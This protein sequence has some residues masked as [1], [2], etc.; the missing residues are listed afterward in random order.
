[1]RRDP[2]FRAGLSTALIFLLVGCD[3]GASLQPPDET[4]AVRSLGTKTGSDL[5]GL[6]A[7]I[8]AFS[9][10]AN[11][12]EHYHLISLGD[13]NERLSAADVVASLEALRQEYLQQFGL[14]ATAGT[15][16]AQPRLANDMGCTQM[17]YPVSSSGIWRNGYPPNSRT[18]DFHGATNC[19]GYNQNGGRSMVDSRARMW[20]GPSNTYVNEQT[21]T[22]FYG[23]AVVDMNVNVTGVAQQGTIATTSICNSG[24]VFGAVG[25]DSAF[26]S[27]AGSV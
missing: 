15:I 11:D 23:Y 9:A 14:R 27:A 19:I 26:S 17:C 21:Y 8:A 20:Y 4:S 22:G 1:M 2:L 3:P 7:S 18:V 25:E 10:I 24:G 12:P 6:N 16:A 5:D 13:G